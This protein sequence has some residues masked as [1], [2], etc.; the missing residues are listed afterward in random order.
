MMML[1]YRMSKEQ[2]LA[3]LIMVVDE[4]QLP[5]RLQQLQKR[6]SLPSLY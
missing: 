3:F 4:T 5:T 2:N 1:W 6:S